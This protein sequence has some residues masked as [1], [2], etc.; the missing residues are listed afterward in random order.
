MVSKTG[1]KDP[2]AVKERKTSRSFVAPT[3]DGATTGR[4]MRAG[5]DYGVGHR[6]PV[7]KEKASDAFAVPMGQVKTLAHDDEL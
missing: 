6:V 3:K 2:I 7:G 1:F 4:F 5:D